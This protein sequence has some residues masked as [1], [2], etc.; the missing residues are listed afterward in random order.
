MAYFPN[1]TAGAILD[2][3]CIYC[4]HENDWGDCPVYAVQALFNYN[5]ADKGQEKLRKA[6]SMLIRDDGI[7]LVRKAFLKENTEPVACMEGLKPWAEKH[8]L[9]V[10]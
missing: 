9:K 5:Q 4:L 7:C 10:F 1:G 8:K 2:N 6:I 3:Q